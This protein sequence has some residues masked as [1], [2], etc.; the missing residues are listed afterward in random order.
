MQADL[1]LSLTQEAVA[2]FP[3]DGDG[4]ILY[5]HVALSGG[6]PNGAFGAGFM[7]GWTQ[8][9]QRPLFKIVTG[10]STGA[11]MAPFVF[12]GPSE[13]ETLHRLYTMT[14]N[15]DIFRMESM[16]VTLLR[17]DSVADSRPLAAMLEKT[18]DAALLRRVAAEH[19]RGRRLYMGTVDLDS[20]RFVIWNMG[21]I[22][23]YDNAQA[24]AL[25]RSVMLASSS[26]PIAFPPVLFEVEAD[27][28]RYDEMHVDGFVG[29][30]VFLNVGAFDLAEVYR[31]Q[32]RGK[33]REDVYVIHNGQ[34]YPPASATPRS[35]Q[36]IA[37]RSIDAAA[38]AGILGDLIREYAFAGM[39]HGGFHWVTLQDGAELPAGFDPKV[40][41]QLYE[42]GYA[43]ARDGPEWRG[44]PPGFAI[45]PAGN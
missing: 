5:S 10:V 26:I 21:R 22:A 39:N 6:G 9:G 4:D 24:L 30:N 20:R 34:L 38:R 25:F 44:A 43:A 19:A 16:L 2:D 15:E 3:V 45:R 7:R 32:H 18:V 31:A 33:A 35:L 28:R 11:L 27:G 37:G 8:S 12:L 17:R 41:T 29:A 42:L 40:M 23:Q 14:G 13:D 1:L 36:G